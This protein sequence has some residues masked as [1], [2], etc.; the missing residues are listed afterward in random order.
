MM[1]TQLTKRVSLFVYVAYVTLS[2]FKWKA[3]EQNE[4]KQY[5][6]VEGEKKVYSKSECNSCCARWERNDCGIRIIMHFS[7]YDFLLNEF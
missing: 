5:K 2:C 7:F 4:E 6:K 3:K 1:D